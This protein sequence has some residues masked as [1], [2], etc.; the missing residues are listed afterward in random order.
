MIRAFGFGITDF[1]AARAW[2]CRLQVLALQGLRFEIAEFEPPGLGF[3]TDDFE[4]ARA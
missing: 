1:E 3:E 4:A 2:I